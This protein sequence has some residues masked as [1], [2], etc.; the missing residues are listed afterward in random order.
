MVGPESAIES[1]NGVRH[2][3]SSLCFQFDIIILVV[4]LAT[5]PIYYW[6][7]GLAT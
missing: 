3:S 2:A 4:R 7:D 1:V 5:M 6:P